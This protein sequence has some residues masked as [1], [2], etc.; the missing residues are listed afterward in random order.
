MLRKLLLLSLCLGLIGS[1]VQAAEVGGTFKVGGFLQ[2]GNTPTLAMS[3]GTNIIISTDT[4]KNLRFLNY[5]GI[6]HADRKSGEIEGGTDFLVTQKYL[7][8]GKNVELV[9][10][11]GIG[12][13]YQVKEGEDPINSSYLLEIGVNIWKFIGVGG[14]AILVTLPGSDQVMVYG[15]LDL[16]NPL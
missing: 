6:F 11:F 12:F 13:L 8:I 15:T 2:Y 9:V 7:D 14:G 5:S 16:I 3:T 1:S 4:T 10:K